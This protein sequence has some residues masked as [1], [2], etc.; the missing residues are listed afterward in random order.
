MT[1]LHDF[2]FDGDCEVLNKLFSTRYNKRAKPYLEVLYQKTAGRW[3]HG[4]TGVT[5][6]GC[7]RFLHFCWIAP[8]AKPRPQLRLHP[9]HVANSAPTVRDIQRFGRCGGVGGLVSRTSL[10]SSTKLPSR[11]GNS[12][13]QSSEFCTHFIML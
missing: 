12:S 10:L 9:P 1:S 2:V 4:G 6:N 13:G 11:H 8:L 3:Y 5:N 7:D